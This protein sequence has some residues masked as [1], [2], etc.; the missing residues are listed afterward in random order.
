MYK[1]PI[2]GNEYDSTRKIHGH[3]LRVHLDDYRLKGCKLENY[4]NYK[5]PVSEERKEFVIKRPSDLRVLNR[6]DAS[7]A[8]AYKAGYRYV[9]GDDCYTSDE[10]KSRGWI[11]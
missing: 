8:A 11:G 2:C 10:A 1:C 9:S 6:D 5:K 7:E 3:M 4:P